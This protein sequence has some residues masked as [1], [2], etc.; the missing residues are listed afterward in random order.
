M[1]I[2]NPKQITLNGTDYPLM[3]P[4]DS[5]SNT[6]TAYVIVDGKPIISIKYCNGI[7]SQDMVR[8]AELALKSLEEND[9]KLNYIPALYFGHF[10]SVSFDTEPAESHYADQTGIQFDIE[11]VTDK[12]TNIKRLS[13]ELVVEYREAVNGYMV[14]RKFSIWDKTLIMQII[15]T[16]VE[17]HPE[18]FAANF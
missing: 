18:D 10:D 1:Q 12:F 8:R 16:Y 14:S 7:P 9:R 6:R 3:F 15:N 2:T 4:L 5:E 13:S 11:R 17:S